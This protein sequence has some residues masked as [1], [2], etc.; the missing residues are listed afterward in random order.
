MKKPLFLLL[1]WA[2]VLWFSTQS[3]AYTDEQ[4]EAKATEIKWIVNMIFAD[5]KQKEKYAEP[6]KAIFEWCAKTCK[7]EL[8]KLASAKIIETYDVDFLWAEPKKDKKEE[9]T[10]NTP[11]YNIKQYWLSEIIDWDTIKVYDENWEFYSV[12]LIWIDAPESNDTRYWYV[13]CYWEEAT[14]HLKD[15][16]WNEKLIQIEFDNSQWL[17][18]KYDRML[19]YLVISWVNLNKQMIRD[20]YAYE[21]KYDK[22]YKYYSEFQRAE[23]DAKSESLWVWWNTTC[24]WLRWDKTETKKKVTEYEENQKKLAEEERQRKLEELKKSYSSSSSS[25][26]QWSSYN[27]SSSYRP[28]ECELHVWHRGERWWCYYINSNWNKSYNPSCC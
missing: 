21:Y 14:K 10:D 23:S 19:W 20:W 18:D 15:L 5:A 24:M 28:S 11:K 1:W 17:Y 12:R 22:V 4:V 2:L 8:S 27:S 25:Y 9:K 3:Y 26:W 13:E 16:V 7:N 6:F